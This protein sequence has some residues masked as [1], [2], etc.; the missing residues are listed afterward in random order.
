MA[1]PI[2]PEQALRILHQ[3]DTD[4]DELFTLEDL[5]AFVQRHNLG[6]GAE[7]LE[8]MFDEA[9]VSHNGLMDIDQLQ[10]AVS[11]KFAHRKHTDAWLRLCAGAPKGK[12]FGS[13]GPVRLTEMREPQPQQSAIRASYEQESAILTFAPNTSSSQLGNSAS[14]LTASFPR[15]TGSPMSQTRGM[16]PSTQTLR[17]L[18]DAPSLRP[19]AGSR[20]AP[21]ENADEN[22]INSII[23]PANDGAAADAPAAERPVRIGFGAQQAFD[24]RIAKT[25]HASVGNGWRGRLPIPVPPAPSPMYYGL[26]PRDYDGIT[27]LANGRLPLRVDGTLRTGKFTASLRMMQTENSQV[28]SCNSKKHKEWA[29]DSAGN[30]SEHDFI[31]NFPRRSIQQEKMAV[32]TDRLSQEGAVNYPRPNL[33]MLGKP[34]PHNFRED[35]EKIDPRTLINGKPDFVTAVGNFWPKNELRPI[36]YH[37]TK[38][39]EP[40]VRLSLTE[41]I[42][43]GNVKMGWQPRGARGAFA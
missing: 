12:N 33:Y 28:G 34:S 20:P 41:N 9:N 18:A 5:Q 16:S 40:S 25:E 2:A 6:F 24:A 38:P 32:A 37:A 14:R 7:Q 27:T 42:H 31:S 29:H 35:I 17:A 3:I 19:F 10:K 11:G 43:P 1:A 22:Y 39:G 4:L 26:H 21:G 30:L 23:A 13:E 15:A 8:G 36:S